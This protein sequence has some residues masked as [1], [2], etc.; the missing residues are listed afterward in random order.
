MNLSGN[1]VL[2]TGGASGIGLALAERF[3]KAKSEVIICGRRQD[4][5]QEAKQKFPALHTKVCDVANANERVALLEW[6]ET[7][8]PETNVLVNNAGIQHR[9]NLDAGT[10]GWEHYRQELLINLEAPVHLCILFIPH[11]KKVNPSAIINV[12]SGL[13]FSPGAFAPVYSATKA[14]LHSFTLSLRHQLS[15]TSI[16]VIEIVPPAV[17]TDLGGPGLHTFGVPVNEF[18]DS[19]MNR[20]ANG[21]QEVG[22]GTS[23]KNRLASRQELDE[24]F[25]RM[26]G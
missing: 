2:I 19:V 24:I 1:T 3:L 4:K 22:Y 15:K 13:A 26:N 5:L 9:V 23:E 17:N 11:L 14:G 8:F 21:E 18:A 16:E 25:K 12:S 10:A 6:I 20:L 7:E